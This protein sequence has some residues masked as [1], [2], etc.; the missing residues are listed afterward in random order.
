[1]VLPRI[2]LGICFS[3]TENFGKKNDSSWK[4]EKTQQYGFTSNVNPTRM[5]S[6]AKEFA[7]GFK[8]PQR[9]SSLYTNLTLYYYSLQNWF[10]VIYLRGGW[11]YKDYGENEGEIE[12]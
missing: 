3:S 2:F 12:K 9:H 4:A 8:G 10:F 5:S 7:I 1:M 6:T 11:F